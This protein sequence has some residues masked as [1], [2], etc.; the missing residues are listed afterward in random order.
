MPPSSVT[1]SNRFKRPARV[2]DVARNSFNAIVYGAPGA[3]KTTLAATAPSPTLIL[4]ADQGLLALQDPH[5]DLVKK[6]GLK[7]D[8]LYVEPIRSL[9]DV[10]MQIKRVSDECIAQPGWWATIVVDNLTELQRIC[11]GDLLRKSDRTVPEIRDWGVILLQMQ[12]V[13]RAIRNLPCNS[14]FICHE[15]QDDTGIGPA[16]SGQIALE[17]AGYVDVLC[18]LVAVEKEVET[19]QGKTIKVIRRLR[20][21]AQQ[22]A[23]PV[24]AKSRSSWLSDWEEPNLSRLIAKSRNEPQTEQTA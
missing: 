14:V 20:C 24:K 18:R 17:L 1:A 6:L 3:G 13:V 10:T 21:H 11:M 16:L 19:P 8:E 7:L 4:D 9:S 23:V 15:K 22:G 5:P 2:S 12:A